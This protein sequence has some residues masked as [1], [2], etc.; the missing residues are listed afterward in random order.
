MRAWG[1]ILALSLFP[2]AQAQVQE[3]RPESALIL[4]NKAWAGLTAV[5]REA[6]SPLAT[7]WASLDSATQEKWL[8][9]ASRYPTLDAEEKQR[10]L[11]RMAEWSRL[12]PS[13]RQKARIG[14]QD[15][16]R[17]S[18][19][20]RQA[21]WER[22]QALSPEQ[23]QA[24]KSRAA[25]RQTT[26]QPPTTGELAPLGLPSAPLVMQARPGVSTIQIGPGKPRTPLANALF[27]PH[28]PLHLA[29]VDPITL[30]PRVP[31]AA[32]AP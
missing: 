23:R 4:R 1:L 32:S 16:Q 12:N 3:A 27:S 20:E 13:E 9:V 11:N 8:I 28:K 7:H 2:M 18:A 26:V 31:R 25:Q 14:W 17:V 15:A 30:Q 19:A 10:L 24:L 29:G 5:Q 22:Y 6:L 21:K